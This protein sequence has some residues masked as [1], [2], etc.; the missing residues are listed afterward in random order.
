M[1]NG[2]VTSDAICQQFSRVMKSQVKIIGK[3]LH[4]WPQNHYSQYGAYYSIFYM[5]II[6]PEHLISL[7]AII[8][9]WFHHCQ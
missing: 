6:C 5:I 9:H 2:M 7:K 8:D 3:S 4:E 1:N